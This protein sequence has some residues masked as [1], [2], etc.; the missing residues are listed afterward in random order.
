MVV[1]KRSQVRPACL[2]MRSYETQMSNDMYWSTI[3][4]YIYGVIHVL[5]VCQHQGRVGVNLIMFLR[6]SICTSL[7][8][9][10]NVS[11]PG[12][13]FS[14]SRV[15]GDIATMRSSVDSDTI[16]VLG[17]TQDPEEFVLSLLVTNLL[18]ASSLLRNIFDFGLS[19]AGCVSGSCG[20]LTCSSSWT[21]SNEGCCVCER[22]GVLV[23]RVT[24]ARFLL[25]EE[26]DREGGVWNVSKAEES[27]DVALEFGLCRDAPLVCVTLLSS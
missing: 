14:S 7:Q 6:R 20:Y 23:P 24:S 5:P 13:R 1:A 19:G 12:T 4:R 3:Q 9:C 18:N 25:R 2:D 11:M 17:G 15:V 22:L 10:A 8:A 16:G 21:N 26:D 27:S